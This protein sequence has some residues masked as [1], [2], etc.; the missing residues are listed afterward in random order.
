MLTNFNWVETIGSSPIMMALIGFSV[1]TMGVAI[2]RLYYY[3][4]RRG[5][6]DQTLERVI[7]KL[8]SGDMRETAR[9]CSSCPHPMGQVAAEILE[10]ESSDAEKAEER[11]MIALSQQKLL[12]ERNL[13]ILG[14]MA[15][16]SPL[17]GLLG[18]V[19]G[20]M[21]AFHDMSATGTAAPS[22][23]AA[24]VA[25]ALLTTAAGLILAV[26]ALMIYNHLSRRMGVMLTVA[27]NHARSIRIALAEWTVRQPAVDE[28]REKLETERIVAAV[29]AVKKETK[30]LETVIQD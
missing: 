10:S 3:R 6:P 1:V 18:T 14:T 17:V 5:N 9:I 11:L 16:V 12:L 20:I 2:E 24:G 29:K 19:W 13:G 21:R 4:K 25:E 30:P 28:S 15:A 8:S 27:E 22:V 26:P 23:V 7:N